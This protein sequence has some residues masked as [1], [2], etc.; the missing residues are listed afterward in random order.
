[1]ADSK[2]SELTS[3]T[4]AGATDTTYLV[5]SSSSKKITIADMFK[6]V[7]TP[8]SFN[9][10]VSIGD[11]NTITTAGTI[12]ASSYNVKFINNPDSGGNCSIEAGLDGQ[13]HVAIMSA[14]SG[15]H[16][17]TISGANVSGTIS[18]DAVGETAILMYD[19]GLSKWWMIGG[20]A[21]F[22]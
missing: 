11:H 8:T 15:G 12:G 4:S 16:T 2:L 21:T 18:F 22:S 19:T 1:M 13:L 7:A 6:A 3:A 5:Q 14:N 10:K 9:D 20:T 17:I